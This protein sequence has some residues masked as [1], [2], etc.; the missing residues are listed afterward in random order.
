MKHMSSKPFSFVLERLRAV[1]SRVSVIEAFIFFLVLVMAAATIRYLSPG[2]S[3]WSFVEIEVSGVNWSND[4]TNG[5]SSFMPPRWLTDAIEVGD[6]RT[7]G[8][9]KKNAE[10]VALDGYRDID[11]VW[12][13][14]VFRLKTT[15][16]S[17]GE[18]LTFERSSL[19][20]GERI[21]LDF[22]EFQIV[23]QVRRVSD[24]EVE[25]NKKTVN[26]VLRAMDIE[27]WLYQY[28]DIG[29]TVRQ[30]VPQNTIA[31]IN[32]FSLEPAQS[33]VLFTNPGSEGAVFLRDNAMAKDVVIHA[34]ME[35]ER[36]GDELYFAGDNLV[37]VGRF[38]HL[39]FDDYEL[40]WVR[41][42]SV[43]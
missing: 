18:T 29:D 10:V 22:P 4:W 23:G 7:G 11:N 15:K 13:N 34:E 39:F 31:T 25:K 40:R 37:K 30:L 5:G 28:I 27:P 33:R 19:R 24:Q 35:V 32:S 20:V 6:S 2:E 36:R 8:D 1:M 9:R 21:E 14:I 43:E 17:D 41:I 12:L 3:S 16:G 26:V 42:E 38:V